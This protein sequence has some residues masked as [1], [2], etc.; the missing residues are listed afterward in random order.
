MRSLE[1]CRIEIDRIDR[2]VVKLFEERMTVVN[3]VA[4]YKKAHNLPIFDESREQ[5]V[6]E[7]NS[8]MVENL[9]YIPYYKKFIQAMM[10]ISKEYQKD[11]NK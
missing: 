7:K 2:Q 9:E 11:K 4:E 8:A 3:D 5:K 1:E 10:D 6:I